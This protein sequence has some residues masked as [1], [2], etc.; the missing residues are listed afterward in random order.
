MQ[1]RRL[2]FPECPA[3]GLVTRLTKLEGFLS[4]SEAL[5]HSLN[6]PYSSFCSVQFRDKYKADI[7]IVVYMYIKVHKLIMG[8]KESLVLKI[9]EKQTDLFSTQCDSS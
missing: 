6:G 4:L 9:N 7:D 2:C 8:R 3:Q 5:K 1:H